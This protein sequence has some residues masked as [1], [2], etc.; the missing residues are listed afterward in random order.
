LLLDDDLLLRVR[1]VGCNL[2]G[3]ASMCMLYHSMTC[4]SVYD[5][6]ATHSCLSM[7]YSAAGQA[8]PGQSAS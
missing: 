5:G 1:H 4:Q 7:T 6:W 2:V 8:R 3:L